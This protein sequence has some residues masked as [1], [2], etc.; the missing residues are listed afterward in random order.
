MQLTANKT[1]IFAFA[2]QSGLIIGIGIGRFSYTALIPVMVNDG[3]ITLTQGGYTAALNIFGYVIGAL[4]SSR[5]AVRFCPIALLRVSLI[6]SVSVL[7]FSALNFGLI[8]LG[9]LRFAIGFTAGI[10]MSIGASIVLGV[11][12]QEQLAN[13]SA[14]IFSG[15]GLGIVASSLLIYLLEPYGASACWIGLASLSLLLLPISFHGWK[16]LSTT[17]QRLVP[18]NK[19]MP[20]S[21]SASNFSLRNLQSRTGFAYGLYGLALAPQTL[22]WLE[23]IS[24]T[25]GYSEQQAIFFW[26]IAG[27]GALSGA[28][29][30]GWIARLVGFYRAV[31]VCLLIGF[32]GLILPII[33]TGNASLFL[34][35]YCFGFSLP[36]LPVVIAGRMRELTAPGQLAA[37]WGVLTASVA[38]GQGAGGFIVATI[39]DWSNSFSVLFVFGAVLYLLSAVLCL[40]K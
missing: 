32:L 9:A 2:A 14:T 25:T 29:I 16:E 28:V 36:G 40:K 22:F 7:I 18:C 8:W 34:A 6:I 39:F 30:A 10:L 33:S 15:I 31:L 4:F 12:K 38:I 1:S 3:I 27:C 20:V 35:S 21:V 26:I 19:L 5:L 24:E 13:V 17:Y 23:F 37:V 11:T